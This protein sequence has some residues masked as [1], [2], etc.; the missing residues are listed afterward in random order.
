MKMNAYT[1]H[2][3]NSSSETDFVHSISNCFKKGSS[4]HQGNTLTCTLVLSCQSVR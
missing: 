2:G 1:F 3:Q 4:V